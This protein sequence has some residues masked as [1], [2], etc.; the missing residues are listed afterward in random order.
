LGDWTLLS[1]PDVVG[2]ATWRDLLHPGA[3]LLPIETFRALEHL[4][5]AKDLGG[6]NA[7]VLTNVG[8][9]ELR[10]GNQQ[11]GERSVR[12]ALEIDPCDVNAHRVLMR[13]LLQAGRKKEAYE[14]ANLPAGCRA[15]PEAMAALEAQRQAL[16]GGGP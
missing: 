14:A 3:L 8:A 10:M 15:L 2:S 4:R 16:L 11:A 1:N 13:A 6:E 12:R 5:M 9:G 7:V